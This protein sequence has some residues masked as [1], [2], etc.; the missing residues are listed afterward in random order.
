MLIHKDLIDNIDY[1]S[2]Y[3][4]DPKFITFIGPKL[5]PYLF[6]SEQFVY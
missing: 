3:S 4:D 1:L 5:K 2:S 6:G